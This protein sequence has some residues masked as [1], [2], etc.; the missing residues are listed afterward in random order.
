[1]KI[2]AS[3]GRD[4]DG[5]FAVQAILGELVCGHAE[6]DGDHRCAGGVDARF[7]VHPLADRQRALGQLMQD[8]AD[9]AVGLGSGVGATDLAEH[10]LLADDG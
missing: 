4:D 9:R 6:R 3:C 8:P 10:L 5:G 2:C 1:M 7:G